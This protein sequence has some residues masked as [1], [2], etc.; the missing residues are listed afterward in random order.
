MHKLMELKE[1][2]IDELGDYADND[3]FSKED[4]ESI[5]YIASGVDHICHIMK[6]DY[7]YDGGSYDGSYD[8]GS[9]EGSRM[10]G[11]SRG[12]SYARG[13]TARR[14]SMGRYSGDYSR[15]KEDLAMELRDLMDDAPDAQTRQEIEKI[16]KRLD[17]IK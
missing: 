11:H 4:V 8:D 6:E 12:R 13:R 10:R 16:V 1:K 3:K 14:D 2:L 17:Q 9:Y 5:K 15:A 7:S